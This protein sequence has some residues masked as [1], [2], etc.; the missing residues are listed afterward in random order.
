MKKIFL[1]L[2]LRVFLFPFLSSKGNFADLAAKKG[3]IKKYIYFFY[4]RL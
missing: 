3:K 2:I 1:L 4:S